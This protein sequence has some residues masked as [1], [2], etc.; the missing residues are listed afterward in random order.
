MKHFTILS[1][2]ITE[3][4][5]L[6]LTFLKVPLITSPLFELQ[7][8]RQSLKDGSLMAIF[9]FTKFDW[10]FNWTMI[11]VH[12]ILLTTKRIYASWQ[13]KYFYSV[14]LSSFSSCYQFKY[15]ACVSLACF[16][17]VSISKHFRYETKE[18]SLDTWKYF[19]PSFRLTWHCSVMEKSCR[20][21]QE[22]GETIHMEG[23]RYVGAIIQM[24]EV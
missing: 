6:Q 12:E 24:Y 23:S 15:S 1:L 4:S 3:I 13:T 9:K 8:A 10:I 7:L 21:T 16:I 22:E 19:S 5:T 18:K 17:L 11:E 20:Q 2:D 14:S